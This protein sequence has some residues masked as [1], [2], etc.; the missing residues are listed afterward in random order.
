MDMAQATIVADAQGAIVASVGV[1]PTSQRLTTREIA[2]ALPI[3]VGGRTAGYVF[4][5]GAGLSIFSTLEQQF[6]TSV[7]RGLLMA[8]LVAGAL[9]VAISLV[10]AR[11]LTAPLASMTQAAQAMAR[12]D[13]SQ[14]VR[15][16]SNDEIG[17]LAVAF[18]SMAASLARAEDVR[19]NLVAD[20]AHELRTPLAVLRADLEALQ[21][22]VYQPTPE[23]LT[24]LREETDLL[25]RL[26][27]DLHELSL[28]EAGQL[29]L[30]RR[31]AALAPLCQQ[32]VAAMEPQ[33]SARG[34][35]LALGQVDGG[36]VSNVD[37]DRIGQ[38][39]RNL[40][41]NALRYTPTGGSITLSCRTDGKG[42]IIW[43]RDTGAGIKPDDLPHVFDRFYRG[44]KSRSRATGG[45]GLG[46]A[47]VKQLV[48]A[49]GGQVWV[50]S[51]LGQG[52]TFFIRLP[53]VAGLPESVQTP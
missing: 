28:A 27:A 1:T 53:Q 11:R 31:L 42:N 50:E 21:D 41:S 46:L 17:R 36:A 44:E 10:V 15:A 18:N 6:V 40:V 20:V 45:A 23:R 3:S 9:A 24:A 52:T 35:T 32:I 48:E 4:G 5:Q 22:G 29:T 25:G 33:A 47:I 34:V 7:N 43:V 19:R 39:L 26:V 38:V 37:P 2:A 51:T 14:R 49:H 16:D 13:L 12:G 8:S 30:E